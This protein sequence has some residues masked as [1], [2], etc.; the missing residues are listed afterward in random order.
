M[1]RDWKIWC[2]TRIRDVLAMLYGL[3]D[4]Q[5]PLL[6]K[7]VA[8]LPVFYLL[9][10]AD[11]IPDVIPILGWLD[12]V[13]ALPAAAYLSQRFTPPALLAALRS[14]ADE[15]MVRRWP[16]LRLQIAV[17][18]AAWAALAIL[19][20]YLFLNRPKQA[21]P[22]HV[23]LERIVSGEFGAADRPGEGRSLSQEQP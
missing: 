5:T 10:P 21:I 13:A 16:R 2:R 19:G 23:M 18:V 22:E 9:M 12:D 15:A 1:K 11:L 20:G 4:P 7:A 17:F 3:R 6:A 14:R 8:V